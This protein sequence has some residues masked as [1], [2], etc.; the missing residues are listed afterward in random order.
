M[1]E[2]KI[3]NKN[4]NKF[5]M[6]SMSI[7]LSCIFSLQVINFTNNNESVEE[8][9]NTSNISSPIFDELDINFDYIFELFNFKSDFND[10]E[11]TFDDDL[12]NNN[13]FYGM[14][15]KEES[16]VNNSIIINDKANNLE[17]QV[18]FNQNELIKNIKYPELALEARIEAEVVINVLVSGEG[19]ASDYRIEYISNTLFS[20]SVISAVMKTE[21]NPSVEEGKAISSWIRIPISFKLN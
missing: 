15:N 4:T 21:F 11:S 14:N 6:L 13:K 19:R 9:Y 12:N 20:D 8:I 17:N 7:F 5:Y 1:N 2:T 10:V 16:E 3:M 18:S